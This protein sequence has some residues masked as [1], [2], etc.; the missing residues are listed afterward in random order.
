MA[1]SSV[2]WKRSA[3]RELRVLP[4]DVL[5][6]VLERAERLADDPFPEGVRKLASAEHTYRLRVGGYR[7]VYSVQ[8]SLLTIEI[9]RVGHRREVYR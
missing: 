1:S 8:S 5:R 3:L 7:I 6:R 2:R 4:K 9:I